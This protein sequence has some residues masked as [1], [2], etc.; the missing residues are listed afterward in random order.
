MGYDLSYENPIGEIAEARAKNDEAYKNQTEGWWS[1]SRP[2]YY[3]YNIFGGGA[4]REALFV[5][6]LLDTELPDDV[7]PGSWGGPKFPKYD[8][9]TMPEGS[10]ASEA[11]REATEAVLSR[12]YGGAIPAFKLGSNDGWLVTPAE[13]QRGIDR[14]KVETGILALVDEYDRDFVRWVIAS[15][16]HGGFRVW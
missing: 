15:I 16:P 11:H 9:E 4:M 14:G 12:D 2:D 6:G 7:E 1:M 5:C 10:P 13:I 3:R 8:S